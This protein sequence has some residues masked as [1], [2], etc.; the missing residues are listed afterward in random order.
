[1]LIEGKDKFGS[2]FTNGKGRRFYFS[3]DDPDAKISA[4]DKAEAFVPKELKNGL[5]LSDLD[6]SRMVY[7]FDEFYQNTAEKLIKEVMELDAE[8]H[9][10]IT[11]MINSYGGTIH[12]L[13][14]ILDALSSAKSQIN[15]VCLGIA[16]SCGAMLLTS[17]KDRYIGKN[18]EVLVHELSGLA[19]GTNSDIQERAQ[20]LQELQDSLTAEMAAE[21]GQ[22]VEFLNK[23]TEGGKDIVF[24]AEEAVAMG[25]VDAVLL[26]TEDLIRE[27]GVTN[28]KINS[29]K[30]IDGQISL[31]IKKRLSKM[32]INRK[33]PKVMKK[34]EL[35]R[36]LEENHSINVSELQTTN[37]RLG[38]ELATATQRAETAED[39]LVK[40]TS[41]MEQEAKAALLEKL[42]DEG[43]ATQVT[44]E[45]YKL[46]FDAMDLEKC[47]AF[48]EGLVPVAN[49]A[50]EADTAGEPSEEEP[51]EKDE[52]LELDTKVKAYMKNLAAKGETIDYMSALQIV[53]KES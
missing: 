21:T 48:V 18:S 24:N 45:A 38:Q 11:V 23:L 2:F 5:T 12:S 9:E 22:S 49:M 27:L 1:M 19:W 10:P 43:K 3:E 33:E 53:R 39:N 30:E 7:L 40:L 37:S 52:R 15:T 41:K 14:S 51:T 42:V 6:S 17:G 16:A 26:N 8:N 44:K 46:A 32:S 50:P 35:L 28:L 34:E 25:L 36:I 13:R 20:E 29:A 47:K 4:R 31:A